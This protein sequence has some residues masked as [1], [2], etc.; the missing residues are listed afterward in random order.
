MPLFMRDF[1]TVSIDGNDISAREIPIA[2]SNELRP[3]RHEYQDGNVTVTILAG[4]AERS[5][6]WRAEVAGW[7]V[8]CNGRVVV[9]ADRTAL[10]GWGLQGYLP[11]FQPKY[12]GFVGMVMFTS[13]EPEALPWTTT[14]RDINRDTR[15]FQAALREMQRISR[16]ILSFLDRLY[17]SERTSETMEDR[18]LTSELSRRDVRILVAGPE[19]S[20]KPPPL[21]KRERSV[22]I[23]YSVPVKELERARKC[24]GDPGMSARQIGRH[25]F[26]YFLEQECP[27]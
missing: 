20:F 18:K 11:S 1:I 8:L 23:Q 16:P 3:S 13:V 5:P 25:A 10:T 12:R 6:D 15:L 22:S 2:S 19:F 17:P 27:E 14:K 4:L 26:D 7:Y 9:Y 24:I 21:P